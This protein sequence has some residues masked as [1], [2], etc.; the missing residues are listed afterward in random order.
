MHEYGPSNRDQSTG[1]TAQLN[2]RIDRVN[3]IDYRP[4]PTFGIAPP[5]TGIV[6]WGMIA[7]SQFPTHRDSFK[8]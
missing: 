5:A 8:K 6:R 4:V 1:K 2:Y 7:Y 3:R